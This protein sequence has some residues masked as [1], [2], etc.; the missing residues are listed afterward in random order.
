MA[1]P[2]ENFGLNKQTWRALGGGNAL[3]FVYINMR[4]QLGFSIQTH[5]LGTRFPTI[6]QRTLFI[7]SIRL[8]IF[9]R[10]QHFRGF[11][12]QEKNNSLC[13][14]VTTRLIKFK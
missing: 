14:K 7:C 6:L 4:I 11:M 12:R 1:A 13:A 3:R 2:G 8:Q 5:P 9:A 10:R